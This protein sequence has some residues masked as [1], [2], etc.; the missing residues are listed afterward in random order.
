MPFQVIL[1][2]F[3]YFPPLA[4]K[5][6][7]LLSSCLTTYFHLVSESWAADGSRALADERSDMWYKLCFCAES[8]WNMQ[9]KLQNYEDTGAS[10]P[11]F[12]GIHWGQHNYSGESE[13]LMFTDLQ[14]TWGPY[15]LWYQ[16]IDGLNCQGRTGLDF[17][18]HWADGLD[19]KT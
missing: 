3:V 11:G 4:W 2:A 18:S 5:E 6:V 8:R 12:C 1:S 19:M 15:F 10:S 17:Q 16:K 14:L 13:L 7:C 9:H